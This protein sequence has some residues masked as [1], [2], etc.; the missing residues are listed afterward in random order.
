[1]ITLIVAR[2]SAAGSPQRAAAAAVSIVRAVAPALRSISCEL[3]IER[4][5]PVDMSPHTRL[6]ARFWCGGANS[7]CTLRQ[8][9][10][11]SSATSIASPVRLPCPISD[12]ATRMITVSSG[13]ITIQAVISGAS[14]PARAGSVPNGISKPSASAPPA[15][16]TLARKERRLTI[17]VIASS[18]QLIDRSRITTNP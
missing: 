18:W 7:V 2:H 1:V 12:L 14:P 11:S 8:S 5:P 3:R 16:D 4:L 15:A 6:R 13:R 10:A 17:P 9:Q